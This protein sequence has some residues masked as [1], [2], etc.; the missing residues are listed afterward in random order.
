MRTDGFPE[1]T[2]WTDSIPRLSLRRTAR[3]GLA[4]AYVLFLSVLSYTCYKRPVPGDFDRY[5]YEALIR[6]KTQPIE[7]IFL[8]IK[9]ESPRTEASAILDSPQ[10]LAQ[11]EPLYAIRPLY[12]DAVET[13]VYVTPSIQKAISLVSALALFMIGIVLLAWTMRPVFCGLIMASPAIVIVGRA[14]T[15]D[16]LS[17]LCIVTATWLLMKDRISPAVL[18]LLLSLFIRTD[19]ILFALIALAWLTVRQKIVWAHSVI[20]TG[21]SVASI[22]FINHFSGNYGWEVLFRHSFIGGKYPAE[23]TSHLLAT[24]YLSVFVRGLIEIGGQELA[25]WT[26]LGVGAWYILP[27]S[28]A[29]RSLL[30]LVA[31][32]AVSHF[33]LFPSPENRYFTWAYLIVGAAFLE[34]IGQRKNSRLTPMMQYAPLARHSEPSTIAG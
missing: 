28:S 27:R 2:G 14:G 1:K 31:I 23:I 4:V 33:L 20:L 16:A 13:A 3:T 30:S 5:I 26:L 24:E 25:L 12:L 9:H 29:Y 19:N 11:L 18:L 32:A 6:S 22:F 10:H 15:P 8:L 17:A 21:L 7:E 34:G